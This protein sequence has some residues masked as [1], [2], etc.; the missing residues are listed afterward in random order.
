MA[1]SLMILKVFDGG[2]L[3]YSRMSLN[4]DAQ[5]QEKIYNLHSTFLVVSLNV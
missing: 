5:N 3:A 4:V 2:G 1:I